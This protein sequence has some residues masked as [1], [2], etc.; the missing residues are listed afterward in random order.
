MLLLERGANGTIADFQGS[1]PLMYA[2]HKGHLPVVRL[3]LG[4]PS[5]KA[6][7]N[8]RNLFGDSA[9]SEVCYYGHGAVARVLLESGADPT[10]AIS[11]QAP[12]G[13]PA[14]ITAQG[15]REC[16]AALEVRLCS[17]LPFPLRTLLRSAG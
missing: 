7:V 15:R 8:H 14:S 11:K 16:V 2:S 10:M 6:T 4:H 12:P 1:I 9:L 17:A 13:Y 5:V 3:L